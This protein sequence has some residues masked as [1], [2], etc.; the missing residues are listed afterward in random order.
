MIENNNLPLVSIGVPVYNSQET[1]LRAL[2]SLLKQSYKNIEIIVSDNLSSDNTTS[3]IKLLS[4]S[5]KRI[6]HYIQK[7]N[8]G[9]MP[10][11][12][13]VLEKSKGEYFFW[14][15]G[16][17]YWDDSFIEKGINFFKSNNDYAAVF[18]N[19]H[20]MNNKNNKIIQSFSPPSFNES[21]SFK[22]VVSSLNIIHPNLMYAIF[23]TKTLK[24]IGGILP[25]NYNDVYLISKISSIGKF[26]IINEFLHFV[27]V[28]GNVRIPY[29]IDGT[30]F[31]LDKYLLK[32]VKLL[33]S[34]I[35][36]LSEFIIFLYEF[37]KLVIRIF[38][39]WIK[40]NRRISKQI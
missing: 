12:Q 40:I 33:F 9:Q 32:S 20:L 3:I 14:C 5:D 10:N 29:S 7:K 4:E 18:C 36:N 35:K 31:N 34:N 21:S 24:E 6:N 2:S 22:R 16:D 19:F 27:G 38:F 1:I 13:F 23:K 8:I 15:S 37:P 17:D 39:Y 25:F 26:H 30:K 28:S 11:F